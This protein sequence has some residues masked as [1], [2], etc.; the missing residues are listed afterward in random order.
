MS[1]FLQ[2][3]SLFYITGICL[4]LPIDN[5]NIEEKK[6]ESQNADNL[7]KIKWTAE[8]F[9]EK[10]I[11]HEYESHSDEKHHKKH[12]DS[13][14]GESQSDEK[15]HKKHHK[16]SDEKHHMKKHHSKKHHKKEHGKEVSRPLPLI[17]LP[18]EK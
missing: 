13:H 8:Q 6:V 4:S 11:L 12:H 5:Q 14:S 16:H 2:I 3:I 15:P 9:K 18:I 17:Q 1:K 7:K 10:H